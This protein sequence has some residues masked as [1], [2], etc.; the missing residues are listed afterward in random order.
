MSYFDE[1]APDIVIKSLFSKYD[2]DNSGFISMKELSNLLTDDLDLSPEQV[3]T[4]VLLLDKDANGKLSFNEFK[5][6]LKSGEKFE[7]VTDTSRFYIMQK[8]VEYYKKYDLDGSG[9]LDRDEFSKL[10]Y[11]VG[12]NSQN[13][14]CALQSMDKDNNNKISFFEF[15][16]WLNWI[17][18]KNL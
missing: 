11:E 13:L 15:L 6:W 14:E 8:A 16:K 18:L 7:I 12:G 10:H 4:Y 3:E 9:W 1:H 2:Q 17:N 5:A